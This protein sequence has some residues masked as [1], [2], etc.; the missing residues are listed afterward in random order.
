[1][2]WFGYR[3]NMYGK[4][5]AYKTLNRGDIRIQTPMNGDSKDYPNYNHH[6]TEITMAEYKW[7]LDMLVMKYPIPQS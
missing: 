5:S 7:P 2:P 1:M 4:P 6:Q 3:T